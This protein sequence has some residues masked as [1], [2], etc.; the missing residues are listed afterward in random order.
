[1]SEHQ[2]PTQARATTSDP[3]G[4][5]KEKEVEPPVSDGWSDSEES[6][7][8]RG[9]YP[10]ERFPSPPRDGSEDESDATPATVPNAA[11]SL[12]PPLM[13][14]TYPPPPALANDPTWFSQMVNDVH[15][16]RN[17]LLEQLELA[18][19][20]A[21][22]AL[23]E[24]T[25]AQCELKAEMKQMQNF[26]DRVA[27][28]AG[29]NFVRKLIRDVNWA[30]EHGDDNAGHGE[31]YQQYVE[32]D[33][34][35]SDDD[36]RE[37]DQQDAEN[38]DSSGSVDGSEGDQHD[39]DDELYSDDV[40]S[41][42][43]FESSPANIKR[44]VLRSP[45]L[46]P[47]CVQQSPPANMK[48]EVSGSPELSLKYLQHTDDEYS[49]G[50]AKSRGMAVAN[51]SRKRRLEYEDEDE[52]ASYSDDSPRKKFKGDTVAEPN[53]ASPYRNESTGSEVATPA[54]QYVWSE[55]DEINAECNSD[56]EEYEVE[57][58]LT[59]ELQPS[60]ESLPRSS[61]RRLRVISRDPYRLRQNSRG[62]PELYIP[63][64]R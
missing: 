48:R 35:S 25:L 49:G 58:S 23:V 32:D 46:S 37:V 33:G 13:A 42:W 30:M 14:F 62:E 11:T 24:V 9:E 41:R 56:E 21:A 43:G 5:G 54:S 15:R 20:E 34:W 47:N 18:R 7:H 29:K 36:E 1:M 16:Q 55:A 26:L 38:E 61:V 53:P 59:L 52:E 40:E 31:E 28:V 3:K 6:E 22:E 45:D 60:L 2:N 39:A 27:Q 4:K 19:A 57:N 12:N 63:N 17:H 44:E 50:D 10:L 51:G 64:M 8:E